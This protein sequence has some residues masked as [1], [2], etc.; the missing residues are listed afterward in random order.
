LS[1]NGITLK[2]IAKKICR[3]ISKS[4]FIPNT[5]RIYFLRKAGVNIGDEVIVNEGFTL[6]CDIGY[7]SNLTIEDRTAFGPN[8]TVVVTS[9][10]NNS[11]SREHKDVYPFMEVFGNIAIHHDAWVGA[12]AI[13]LPGVTVGEHSIVGAGAVVTEDVPPFSAGTVPCATKG[14]KNIEVSEIAKT[15]ALDTTDGYI[16][17]ICMNVLDVHITRAPIGGKITYIESFPGRTL[18]P[19]DWRSEIENPRTTL[20]F[21]GDAQ[22]VIIT[23]IGTPYVSKILSFVGVGTPV[24]RG[25]RIGKITWG[26]QVDGIIPSTEIEIL[27]KEGDAIM[28]RKTVLARTVG[29]DGDQR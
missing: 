5:L 16:V 21:E 2:K 20:I 4:S 29:L 25:Q 14:K 12:G 13:I 26:S 10:P 23:E 6:A 24:V 18:S 15:G 11:R 17:G 7:E 28:A 19:K 27:V 8:V 22:K 1:G 9:H 3:S